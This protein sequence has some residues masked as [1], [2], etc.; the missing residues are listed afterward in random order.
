MSRSCYFIA[1]SW[2][3]RPVCHHFKT[4]AEELAARGHQ[5]VVV[6]DH[7]MVEVENHGGNPAIYS[8]PS[9]RP[10]RPR[11]ALFLAD[12]IRRYRPRCVVA[13]FGAENLFLV[14]GRLMR[15]ARRVSW[16]HTL[17]AQL[18]MDSTLPRWK[19]SLLRR[20]KRLVYRAATHFVA[21]S[22]AAKR[23]LCR[24][25]GVPERKCRVFPLGLP[26]IPASSSPNG[27]EGTFPRVICVGRLHPSKGQDVLIRAAALLK[28]RVPELR[29]DFV[30]DGPSR[31]DCLQL[32]RELGVQDICTFPGTLPHGEVLARMAGAAVTAVP[33]RAEAF[34]YVNLESLA[35]GTPVVASAVDG[36]VDLFH[37]GEE[38]YLVPPDDPATLAD[39]L[40][41]L[42]TDRELRTAMSEKA[43]KRA[44][45]F[46]LS[47]VI[48]EQAD[49][50]DEIAE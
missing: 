32:S 40:A 37:D 15:V 19:L 20:R 6:I 43:R 25:F 16:Y 9:P 27:F 29:V 45:R 31:P 11:D 38:G 48:R 36:I 17:S 3:D 5:V 13:N 33:S 50:L 30:G 28:A 35:V 14:V 39:R 46:E 21:N 23:D 18:D 47:K 2:L 49:W 7:R 41:T 22:E 34:G 1:T 44:S 8:W 4:L 26:S 24:V 10:T 12:L 42:L